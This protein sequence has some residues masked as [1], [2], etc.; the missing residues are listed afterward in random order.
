MRVSLVLFLLLSAWAAS[1]HWPVYRTLSGQ[2]VDAQTGKPLRAEVRYGRY[3]PGSLACSP[4]YERTLTDSLGRFSMRVN[5]RGGESVSIIAIRK[6]ARYDRYG[7]DIRAAYDDVYLR[8]DR[9]S[10][11]LGIVRLKPEAYV[12]V[13]A[14]TFEM[15]STVRVW[16]DDPTPYHTYAPLDS[17]ARHPSTDAK[18]VTAGQPVFLRLD[19]TPPG[20]TVAVTRRWTVRV[21][22]GSIYYI[23][24]TGPGRIVE[25]DANRR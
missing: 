18:T 8:F 5:A 25:G 12:R 20:D 11:G 6:D 9:D 2:V 19:V 1:C 4:T 10:V 13:D 17:A 16:I 24:R 21:P 22:H 14:A 15:G 3:P 7:A 23:T